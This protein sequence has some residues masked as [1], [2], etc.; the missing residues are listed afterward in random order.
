MRPVSPSADLDTQR[1]DFTDLPEGSPLYRHAQLG[2]YREY[3]RANWPASFSRVGLPVEDFVEARTHARAVVFKRRPGADAALPEEV[4]FGNPGESITPNYVRLRVH[5]LT[6][7]LK[8]LRSLD[9]LPLDAAAAAHYLTLPA[10]R[11]YPA[12]RL[13]TSIGS[14]ILAEHLYDEQNLG[15]LLEH[16]L[17]QCRR[18]LLSEN[19]WNRA[20]LMRAQ[21]LRD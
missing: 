16:L 17:P 12:G 1:F 3:R 9:L 4:V 5:E 8:P 14:F 18:A 11:N 19:L 6:V 10:H 20:P 15:S 13:D 2:V 21:I 7:H